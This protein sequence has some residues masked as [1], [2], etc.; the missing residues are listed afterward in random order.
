MRSLLTLAKHAGDKG[1]ECRPKGHS[2][3]L[4]ENQI[5]QYNSDSNFQMCVCDSLPVTALCT[6]SVKDPATI[7]EVSSMRQLG[8]TQPYMDTHQST[9]NP[10][11]AHV[12]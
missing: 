1:N 3:K 11:Q 8:N 12:E 2:D 10:Y 5:L 6:P 4:K 9:Q 7:S